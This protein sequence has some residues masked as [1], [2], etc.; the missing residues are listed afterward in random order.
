MTVL[1]SANTSTVKTQPEDLNPQAEQSPGS[2]DGDHDQNNS[3]TEE[4][5]ACS[6]GQQNSNTS[7][8][9]GKGDKT[10]Q[11]MILIQCGECG[12]VF[13][14]TTRLSAH[15]KAHHGVFSECRERFSDPLVR[16]KHFLSKHEAIAMPKK[17]FLCALC[18]NKFHLARYVLDHLRYKHKVVERKKR[19]TLPNPAG[20]EPFRCGECDTAFKSPPLLSAHWKS[21]HSTC[22]ACG[23]C[24]TSA[25][26]QYQH[27][28]VKHNSNSVPAKPFLCGLCGTKYSVARYVTEHIGVKHKMNTKRQPAL[29]SQSESVWFKC[30]ECSASFRTMHC[31]SEHWRSQHGTCSDCGAGFSEP[32]DLYQ[33]FATSHS[34]VRVVDKSF[35]C[36]ICGSQ[37]SKAVCVASHISS[38]HKRRRQSNPTGLDSSTCVFENSKRGAFICI[39]G[40]NTGSAGEGQ[41]YANK[42]E[43]C[44]KRL[45]ESCKNVSGA[46]PGAD[47]TQG[48]A[49]RV[50]AQLQVWGMQRSV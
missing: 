13:Y 9:I 33:H 1:T 40:T 6:P 23:Q 29:N 47:P 32:Q 42:H 41:M 36:A 12:A 45:G 28:L 10:M 48:P 5:E 21:Q 43:E 4:T 15:W 49:D 34:I 50:F 8:N 2:L 26:E 17:P 46:S 44:A 19:S 11:N 30:G 31:L 3:N 22:T 39:S 25:P 27:Y 24:F 18:G 37:Y 7:A 35:W 14:S 38:S 16:H 20:P